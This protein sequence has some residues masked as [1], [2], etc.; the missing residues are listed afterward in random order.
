MLD[1]I[2]GYNQVVVNK[3]DQKKTAFTTPWG[4]FMYAIIPFGLMNTSATFKRAMDIAFVGDK[5][6]VIY[7]DDITVF[8]KFDEEHLDHLKNNFDKCRR[9]GLS[10]N[11]KKSIFS[12][13]EGKLLGHIVSRDGV[14]IDPARVQAMQKLP[15]PR[16]KKDIQKFLGKIKFLR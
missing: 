10:L 7:L 3:E 15:L 5:F 11:P 14:K 9:F 12:L 16:S 4:T 1:G 2:S 13:E 6:V 8:S